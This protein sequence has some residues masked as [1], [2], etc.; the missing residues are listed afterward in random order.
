MTVLA[1]TDDDDAIRYLNKLDRNVEKF[2]VVDDYRSEKKEIQSKRGRD[3]KFSF[4]DYVVKALLGSI[5]ASFDG[6][7]EKRS[8]Q[9]Q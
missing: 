1:C 7:D 3:F 5:D 8:C 9:L 4:G 2:D 6:L